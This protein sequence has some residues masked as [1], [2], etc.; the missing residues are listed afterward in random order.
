MT[1]IVREN[2]RKSYELHACLARVQS[3]LN[4]TDYDNSYNLNLNN[5]NDKIAREH[6]RKSYELQSCHAQSQRNRVGLS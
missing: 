3:Q 2:L 6:L 5:L 1:K 4:N